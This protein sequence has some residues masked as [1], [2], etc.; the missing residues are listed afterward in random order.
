M[1][2]I[3]T[4][5]ARV[6]SFEFLDNWDESKNFV[7]KLK[8]LSCNPTFA[9]WTQ[10]FEFQHR[11]ISFNTKFSVGLKFLY[12]LEISSC[13]SQFRVWCSK[14]G[15]QLKILSPNTKF[16][17]LSRNFKCQLKIVYTFSKFA[18][19]TQTQKFWSSSCNFS[20]TQQLVLKVLGCS[21]KFRVRTQNFELLQ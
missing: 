1:H 14:F 15:L 3:R 16:W 11:I 13:N 8:I 10:N 2:K 21:L 12:E 7:L 4:F 19:H 18:V 6:V 9:V 17:F 20:V 5:W